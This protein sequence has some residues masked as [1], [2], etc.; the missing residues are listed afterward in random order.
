MK[1]MISLFVVAVVFA[2][3]NVLN[4]QEYGA[5]DYSGMTTASVAQQGI[6]AV[7]ETQP[8]ATADD[9][10]D[11]GVKC[12]WGYRWYRRCTY[13]T[14]IVY[15]YRPVVTYWRW[16]Y[17]Y[18][19]SYT[20]RYIS[21]YKSMDAKSATD[22]NGILIEKN[23]VSGTPLASLGIV[24]GDVITAIDGTP[25]THPSQL[26]KITADSNV[27][28]IRAK[29]N[30]SENVQANRSSVGNNDTAQTSEYGAFEY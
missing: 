3:C 28:V 5:D 2:A 13:Y 29:S 4:A 16:T 11:D 8:A 15:Y 19:Y 9:S 14:P 1:R 17:S 26:E 24:K 21:F 23:P 22:E 20:Y 18:R 10:S 12:F 7:E 27:K 30:S 6:P 25:I